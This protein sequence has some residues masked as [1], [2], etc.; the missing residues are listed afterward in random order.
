MWKKRNKMK[1]L[2]LLVSSK[3]AKNI[4]K[5]IKSFNMKLTISERSLSMRK[6]NFRTAA[7]TNH[8]PPTMEPT[9]PLN[10]LTTP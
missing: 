5:K 4:K 7:F 10:Y 1:C 6:Y 2:S 9:D 3:T 8:A